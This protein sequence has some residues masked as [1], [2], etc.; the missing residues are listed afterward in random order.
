MRIQHILS[1]KY[2]AV[3]QLEDEKIIVCFRQHVTES[4]S[5]LGAFDKG[6]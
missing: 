5:Y 3:R 4:T 6:S 2:N 1:A